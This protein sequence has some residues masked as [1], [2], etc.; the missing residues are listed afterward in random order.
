MGLATTL[1]WG[2]AVGVYLADGRLTMTRVAGT[3]SGATVVARHQ[4]ELNEQS[5]SEALK[6]LL[7]K[8]LTA[9]E[10]RRLPVC[11]GI[12]P[13]QTFFSTCP[14]PETEGNTG[15]STGQLLSACGM[16]DMAAGEQAVVGFV[17]MKLRGSSVYSV[18]ACRR[19]LAEELC[20]AAQEA[21]VQDFRLEPGP[22]SL[23]RGAKGKIPGR[24]K[25]AVC[26]LLAEA[27]GLAILVIHDQPVLWRRF[28]LPSGPE[29]RSIASAVRSLQVYALQ[30]LGVS[31]VDGLAIHGEMAQNLA[32]E[33]SSFL[34]L[35]TT[36]ISNQGL[37]ADVYS[38]GLALSAK[39]SQEKAMDM[40]QA[41]KPPPSLS[42]MFP[43]KLAAFVLLV[44]GAMGFLLWDKLQSLD[45]EY[46]IVRQQ[47]SSSK[48][49]RKMKTAEIVKERKTL[50]GEVSAVENFLATRIIWSDYLRDL[51]SRL[52]PNAYLSSVWGFAEFKG[53]SKRK[54]RV[55]SNRSLTMRG[56]TQFAD[57]ESAPIE[58]DSFLNSLR[59]VEIL[60]RDFPIVTLAEIKWRREAGK[61][62]ALFTIIALP[63]KKKASK[64]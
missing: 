2:H 17:G 44:I 62:T 5:A 37:N 40:F 21:E 19:E 59:N 26:V 63:K 10:R 55:R 58:I 11:I 7:E 31:R 9:R 45:Q 43:K 46:Q 23:L 56:V 16:G 33:I 6:D 28:A 32:D 24:W 39:K 61:E 35:D 64:G 3:L 38:L 52:P 53:M 8:Q 1:S 48:W 34:S 57:R 47:N 51:P 42:K 29:A 27:G 30:K 14:E 54:Q 4:Q 60:R 49:A 12:S 15:V 50:S 22:W 36:G 13:E 20:S 25:T 41:L 18:A